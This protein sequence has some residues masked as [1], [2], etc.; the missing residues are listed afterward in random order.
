MQYHTGPLVAV[1]G[2]GA[3]GLMAAL[4]AAQQGARVVVLE[5]GDRVGRKLMATGNGRCNLTNL[6]ASALQYHGNL[7]FAA[8]VLKAVSPRA[9]L[10]RFEALGLLWHTEYE[11]RVYPHSDQAA[12]VLDVLRLGC[13]RHGITTRC[14]SAVRAIERGAQGFTL[15]LASGE[16]LAADR[17][18]VATGGKASPKLGS[19]GSGYALLASLGHR[20]T[21]CYPALAQLRCDHP[22]LRS[23]KGLRVSATASLLADQRVVR[24]EHGEILFTDY[25]LSGIAALGLARWAEMTLADGDRASVRVSLL[26][27]RDPH[28]RYALVDA[29]R[30]LFPDAPA[31]Q[32]ATGFLPRRVGEALCKEVGIPPDLPCAA[33]TDAHVSQLAALLG[34]WHFAVT[35]TQ[36]FE[37]AQVTA[38]GAD[39]EAFDDSTMQSRI[40]PGLYAAGEVLNVDGD[41]GGF[42]LQFA[43]ASG[44]IAGQSAAGKDML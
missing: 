40:V 35:G 34:E 28:E 20:I 3:A 22:A 6:H 14:G 12:A 13:E 29:R 30:T 18:I 38:G 8:E 10:A 9:V 11:G 39:T 4:T 26:P 1:V 7:L 5:H 17:V 25:G 32:F 36:G 21:P 33:L 43:W 2:G 27:E 37:H 42:N 23:L 15:T 19:D 16:K 31:G 24:A 41:C 44:I